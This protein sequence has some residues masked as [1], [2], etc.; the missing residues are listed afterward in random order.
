MAKN[1]GMII[2]AII[3][4]IALVIF[5]SSKKTDIKQVVDPKNI[6]MGMV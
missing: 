6:K 3:I 4:L 5:F 2:A 1:K